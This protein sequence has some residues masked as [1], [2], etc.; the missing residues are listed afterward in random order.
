MAMPKTLADFTQMLRSEVEH[1][2]ITNWPV[3][4]KNA[5]A[6]IENMRAYLMTTPLIDEACAIA[7]TRCREYADEIA[8]QGLRFSAND[9]ATQRAR[10]L[11]L[12]SI[13]EL[14]SR[15]H[16]ARPSDMANFLARGW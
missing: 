6:H 14:E 15:L 16:D 9:A 7:I 8:D 1:T 2:N 5:N 4:R 12:N 13:D 3:L 10:N 11:A